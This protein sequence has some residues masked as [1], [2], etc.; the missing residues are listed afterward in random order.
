M[1]VEVGKTDLAVELALANNVSPA[2]AIAS[3]LDRMKNVDIREG[4]DEEEE[5][6]RQMRIDECIERYLG[7]IKAEHLGELAQYLIALRITF[8]NALKHRLIQ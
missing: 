8:S 2:F 4:E 7:R 3:Q 6:M 1:L 5:A